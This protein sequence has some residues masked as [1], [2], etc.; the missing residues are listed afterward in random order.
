MKISWFDWVAMSCTIYMV[1]CNFATHVTCLLALMV[2]KHSELQ[3]SF[4][5]QKVVRLVTKPLVSH[6]ENFILLSNTM[7]E[8]WTCST[9]YLSNLSL[10]FIGSLVTVITWICIIKVWTCKGM[11]YKH[12]PPFSKLTGLVMATSCITNGIVGIL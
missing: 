8:G 6:N 2:Y 5:I 7:N 12:V 11:I 10:P 1:S 9:C 4:V 3:V